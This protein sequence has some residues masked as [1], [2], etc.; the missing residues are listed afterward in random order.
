[1]D[2]T[3]IKEIISQTIA[4]DPHK[5]DIEK[6]SLFGSFLRGDQNKESD[7]DLLIEFSPE[8]TV[9]FFKLAQLRRN[10]IAALGKEVDLLTPDALNIY[11]RN[12][13]PA[14]TELPHKRKRQ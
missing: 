1:M 8:A 7:I 5:N 12:E 3:Q 6:I 4:N 9:G 10:L 11:F 14:Q 2:K 13:V